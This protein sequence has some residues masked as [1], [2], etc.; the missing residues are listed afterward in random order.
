MGAI[1]VARTFNYGGYKDR[2]I[3]NPEIKP[4]LNMTK[5]EYKNSNS[6]TLNHFYEKLL[7]LKNRMNTTT[8]KSIAEHR[9]KFMEQFLDE[10]YKEWNGEL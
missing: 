1:G 9:H 7:L 4:N 2:E 8:G 10:F 3:Y 5:E 6:P